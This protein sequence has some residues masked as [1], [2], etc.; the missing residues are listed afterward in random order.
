[1]SRVLETPRDALVARREDILRRLG[2]SYED[3]RARA[4]TYRLVGEEW[5]AWEEVT[6]I[7]YL[8][9]DE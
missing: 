5:D 4:A 2:V 8:L 1:M 3:L 9:N 7:D 6:E